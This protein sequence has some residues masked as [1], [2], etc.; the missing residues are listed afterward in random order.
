M[1]SGAA[2]RTGCH[3]RRHRPGC[4][5]TVKYS[6]EFILQ[7][8]SV[9]VVKWTHSSVMNK[10]W[11]AERATG[12]LSCVLWKIQSAVVAQLQ[13]FPGLTGH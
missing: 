5:Q 6:L 8:A 11:S 7:D 10:L 9:G 12:L 3:R 13:A 4:P 2:M 1:Q